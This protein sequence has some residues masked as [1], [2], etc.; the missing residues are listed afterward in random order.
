MV[1]FQCA[2]YINMCSI[3]KDTKYYINDPLFLD[4]TFESVS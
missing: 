3:D 1:E 4:F 2:T